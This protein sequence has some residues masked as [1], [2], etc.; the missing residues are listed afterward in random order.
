MH[1][2]FEQ[3]TERIRDVIRTSVVGERVN[4]LGLEAD[5]DDEGTDFLR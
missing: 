4:N 1:A 5:R 2:N 3:L